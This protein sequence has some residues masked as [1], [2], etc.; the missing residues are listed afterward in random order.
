M[1]GAPCSIQDSEI[2]CSLPSSYDASERGT[3]LTVHVKLSRIMGDIIKFQS[4]LRDIADI[5]R[6]IENVSARTAH[7]TLRTVST[8]TNHLFL[9][10]HQLYYKGTHSDIHLQESFI[11]FNQDNAFFSAFI[12]VL[13]FFIEPSLVPDVENYISTASWLLNAQ[14][15]NGD[16]AAKQ[17]SKELD[18]L[19]RM[20]LEIVRV[21][22]QQLGAHHE[23]I[24]SR[25]DLEQRPSSPDNF[26]SWAVDVENIDINHTQIL[27][28]ADQLDVLQESVWGTNF[29]FEYSNMWN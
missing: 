22:Q 20:T 4:V 29:E 27:D 9:L 1:V 8:T 2:T 21:E 19:Q 5:L 11:P 15:A 25:N 28:L 7:P 24:V 17:R 12:V 16:L 3:L 26:A 13:A 18:L 10:Y 14:I 6:E 23:D